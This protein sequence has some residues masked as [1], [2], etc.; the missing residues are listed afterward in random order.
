MEGND[1]DPEK[2]LPFT[3]DDSYGELG[4]D[5]HWKEWIRLIVLGICVVPLKLC[6]LLTC[7]LGYYVLIKVSE[8][9][10][11][12]DKLRFDVAAFFGKI[13]CRACLFSLG[14]IRIH[15]VSV[16]PEIGTRKE[17]SFSVM[18][19]TPSDRLSSCLCASMTSET[20]SAVGIVSNHCSWCDILLH[21][22]RY[23][24]SFVAKHNTKDMLIVGAIR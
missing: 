21:M 9:C 2:S 19:G 16:K 6:G 10:L 5:I 1:I 3:R 11:T 15:W 18:N 4:L 17:S 7:L 13:Y 20:T 23:F 22:N 8:F 24:P 12:S 14:F